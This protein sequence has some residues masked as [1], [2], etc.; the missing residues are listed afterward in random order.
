[1]VS[2]IHGSTPSSAPEV[3]IQRTIEGIQRMIGLHNNEGEQEKGITT[4]A[5]I[6]I[7]LA[8]KRHWQSEIKVL[9]E[10]PRDPEKLTEILKVK[11]KQYE[12]AKDS[13]DIERLI[14]EIEMLKFVLYVYRQ[15]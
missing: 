10:A 9:R 2:S 12:K 3:V 15:K 7:S 6:Q 13:E 5:P 1:L 4:E 11:Q 14:P 8:A